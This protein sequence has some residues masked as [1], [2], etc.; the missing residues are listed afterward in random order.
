MLE[1]LSQGPASVSELG[2]PLA[3][4][5]AAAVQ[6]VQ[7]LEAIGLVRSQRTGRTRTCSLS[8]PG[9]RP[10]LGSPSGAASG[11]GASTVSA[12]TLA[13]RPLPAR[14][15]MP[16]TTAPAIS[17]TRLRRTNHRTRVSHA[18][19]VIERSYPAHTARVLPAALST[20]WSRRWCRRPPDHYRGGAVLGAAIS[21]D[22]PRG[23]TP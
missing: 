22:V 21:S 12:T 16:C 20:R 19:F 6:H 8:P 23:F 2:K 3:M 1:R 11:S 10:R 13:T 4:S 14:H 9:F 7:V 18:T 15:Q 5:Q 17:S